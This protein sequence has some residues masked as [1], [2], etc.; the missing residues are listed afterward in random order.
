MKKIVLCLKVRNDDIVKIS[1]LP[2]IFF[3]M[4]HP[5]AILSADQFLYPG[6]K[7]VLPLSGART[8][9]RVLF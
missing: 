9:V 1:Y 3:L 4:P 2:L 6:V 8:P 7:R 5:L